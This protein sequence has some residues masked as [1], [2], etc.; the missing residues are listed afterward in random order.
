MP[1]DDSLDPVLRDLENLRAELADVEAR[2]ERLTAD[3]QSR[4]PTAHQPV[5]P[6]AVAH[7]SAAQ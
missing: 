5:A 4:Q 2:L 6:R 7:Q 1:C 3:A